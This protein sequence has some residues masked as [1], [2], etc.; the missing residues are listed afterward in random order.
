RYVACR[1]ER[2]VDLLEIGEVRGAEERH[3]VPR[4]RRLPPA[5]NDLRPRPKL[6]HR[7]RQRERLEPPGAF[8]VVEDDVHPRSRMFSGRFAMRALRSAECS[9]VVTSVSPLRATTT[10]S[11]TPYSTTSVPSAWTTL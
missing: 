1:H 3:G 6:R 9:F 2:R 5:A 4:Q 8:V 7:A 10:R 11:V